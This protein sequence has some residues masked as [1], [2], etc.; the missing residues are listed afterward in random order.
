MQE[1]LETTGI[2]VRDSGKADRYKRPLV[3]VIL[4][5]GRSAG[6]VLI[7]EGLAKE[8]APEYEA[9]WCKK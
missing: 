8:W 4:P 9:D 3:W 2:L 6:S 7:K 1:L 5:D